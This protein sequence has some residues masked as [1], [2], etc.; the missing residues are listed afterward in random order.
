[1]A[2][3]SFPFFLGVAVKSFLVLAAAWLAVLLVRKGSAAVRHLVWCAAFAALLALPLLSG[4]LPA[5][6]IPVAESFLA[7]ASTFSVDAS[8]S[9]RELTAHAMLDN[10]ASAASLSSLPDW[11]FVLL[12]AWAA[13]VAISLL[14]LCIG[15]AAMLRLRRTARPFELHDLE[16]PR[17]LLGIETPIPVLQ[18]APGNMPMTHGLYRPALYL[19]AD[20]AHWTAER[21]RAVLLHELAH[22][23]RGDHLTHLMARFALALYWWNPLAWAA[24]REFLKEREKAADDVVL[25]AGE[26]PSAYASHL[27]EIARCL[28][29]GPALGWAGIAAARRSQL[30]GRLLSILDGGRNRKA[31]GGLA[32][33]A[34]SLAALVTVVPV[35]AMQAGSISAHAGISL[36]PSASAAAEFLKKGDSARDEGKFDQ[37]RVLYN[38]VLALSHAGR[39]AATALI[40]LGTI[41]LEAKQIEPA[42]ADFAQAQ[43][44]DSSKAAEALLWTAI[45]R[46]RQNNPEAA[47]AFFQSALAASDPASL[48]TATIMDLY[49]RFLTRHDRSDE[50]R[51]LRQQA[52]EIRKTQG[53]RTP[54]PASPP[55]MNR[56]GGDVKPPVLLSKTEPQYTADARLAKYDGTVMLYIEVG[57]DGMPHN[58]RVVRGLGFGLDE[59]A[60][61]ALS[62]WR[63][64]PATRF[65]QPVPVQAHVEVN[66]RLL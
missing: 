3:I 57:A 40:R 1:M 64:K 41:E 62:H 6:H 4:I 21:R 29:T 44:A 61:E 66:F 14:Q 24:W 39:D 31:A 65:G 48:S 52:A 38:K 26:C 30:E 13:G 10:R 11:R 60:I 55:D 43:S 18:V 23:G 50:A 12:F 53:T 46:D 58:I 27:L 15:W 49:A 63:F 8:T 2:S 34:A 20:A 47:G 25:A 17:R 59:R 42:I 22:V 19:P 51:S 36:Q 37:A 5:L 45:A 56:I 54:A 9:A 32:A 7:S 28:Q 35:A 33:L 16:T